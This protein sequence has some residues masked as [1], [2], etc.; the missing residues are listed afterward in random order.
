MTSTA[1]PICMYC[2]H[3]QRDA[4]GFACAAFPDGI[5]EAIITSETDHRLPVKGDHDI[6]F[7]PKSKA[8]AAYADEVFGPLA[9]ANR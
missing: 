9:A 1:T 3:Y 8:G 5:P 2:K 7:Q 6:Q 4:E